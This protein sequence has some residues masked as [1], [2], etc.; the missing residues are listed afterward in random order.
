MLETVREY[1]LERLEA[2]GEEREARHG[3]AAYYLALAEEARQELTG[4][5]QTEWF[6]R[7]EN[8]H[9]YL[10]AALSWSLERGD[11]ETALQMNAELWWF[12]YK[13]GHLSEGRRCQ[14]SRRCG[15]PG[16][17]Q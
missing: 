12:W 6:D 8:E 9:D 5:R 2:A 11:A 4:P 10:R 13:R 16:A 15:D 3:H 17:G 1:A 14:H 7:L